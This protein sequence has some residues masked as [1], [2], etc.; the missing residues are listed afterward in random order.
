MQRKE[1]ACKAIKKYKISGRRAS[2]IFN[3]SRKRIGAIFTSSLAQAEENIKKI[4]LKYPNYGYRMI[5]AKLRLEG[6]IY[7]HKKVYRV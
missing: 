7:N 6:I 3:T 4:A 1:L 5:A 2:N